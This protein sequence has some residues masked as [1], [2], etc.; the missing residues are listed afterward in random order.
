MLENLPILFLIYSDFGILA[1]RLV[2]G[3]ILVVHGWPKLKDIRGTAEWMGPAGF[4][5]G[6]FW[7]AIVSIV[8][9]FGGAL[10]LLG[11]FTHY[12]ALVVVGE[13]VVIVLWRIKT[14]YPFKNGKTEFDLLM[15]AAALA[16]A[17]LGG[18]AWQLW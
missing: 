3:A 14:R 16:L 1:L 10:L 9:T 17:A 8:E 11:I 6:L 13:F 2:V 5:P 15:L 4:K 18:G 7:A 12:I